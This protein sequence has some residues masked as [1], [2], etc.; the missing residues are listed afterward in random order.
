M[1]D[2]QTKSTLATDG[3]H[4]D[5]HW[6]AA[7]LLGASYKDLGSPGAVEDR[8]LRHLLRSCRDD[9][10]QLLRESS[11]TSR[12]YSMHFDAFDLIQSDPV[13]GFL[14]IRYPATLLP[15]LE[16]AIVRAQQELLPNE[17]ENSSGDCAEIEVRT[18][19]TLWHVKGGTAVSSPTRV[20]ARLVHLP[21]TC[22]KPT[23]GSSLSA[24]DVGKIWQVS[25]I[26]VRTGV[27][28]M[29]ESARQYKCSGIKSAGGGG[30]RGNKYRGGGGGDQSQ[31]PKQQCCGRTFLVHAD[32]EQRNNAL[33]EPEVC[34]GTLP[35]GER[36]P[37]NKF[38]VV[39]G[40][41]VHTDYQEIKIQDAVGHIPRS[42]LVKLQHDLVD[43]CQPGDEVVV[44]GILLAQW[45]QPSVVEG[46]EC[47]VSMACKHNR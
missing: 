21:P 39:E 26:V 28:Q 30:W 45:Q 19:A 5:E 23:L 1:I 6:N 12:D 31:Q 36:C 7:K 10:I 38:E 25:G 24:Q 41:S 40:G 14:L 46:M 42:L 15:L 11:V 35:T 18:T 22:C 20:H 47:H 43:R 27:V 44:V 4:H 9:L 8:F 2:P 29:Y 34:P 17:H 32:L 13:L 33:Q 16:G 37:G 3:D